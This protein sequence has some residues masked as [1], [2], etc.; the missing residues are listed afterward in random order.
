MREAAADDLGSLPGITS[1]KAD[2]KAGAVAI[3]G[4]SID[5]AAVKKA[6]KAAGYS[7][8]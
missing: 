3:E 6:I 8:L 1:V 2:W 5:T 4:A 7:P